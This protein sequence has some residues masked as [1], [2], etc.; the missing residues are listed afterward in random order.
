M[1]FVLLPLTRNRTFLYCY[2]RIPRPPKG[3]NTKSLSSSN[4][5]L[6]A[7]TSDE[8]EPLPSLSDT[9]N[10]V[11]DRMTSYASTKW[12][13]WEHEPQGSMKRTITAY[14]NKALQRIP[15]EEWGLKS[16][17][18]LSTKRQNTLLSLKSK[19]KDAAAAAAEQMKKRKGKLEVV[20]PGAAVDMGFPGSIGIG[21][22]KL[23]WPNEGWG[24]L[25][26]T[27]VTEVLRELATKRQNLHRKRMWGCLIGLPFT[28]PVG[29]LPIIPNI[30]GFYLTFRAWSHYR[31]LRGSQHLEFLLNENLTY[32]SPS[33][34]LATIY[35]LSSIR[36]STSDIR[37]EIEALTAQKAKPL[38]DVEKEN[39]ETPPPSAHQNTVASAPGK[40]YSPQQQGTD[41]PPPKEEAEK[42]EETGTRQS[43]KPT[44][45]PSA[46]SSPSEL[47][48][49]PLLI[50]SSSAPLIADA[51]GMPE[52][53]DELER[54]IWQIERANKAAARKEK[55]N[56]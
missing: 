46:L 37:K 4:I 30:P 51:L 17:P 36:A 49:D 45:S 27:E 10:N 56:A 13:E 8:T 6:P 28:L 25:K 29:I 55:A 53:E 19:H 16:I 32:L 22:G 18:P 2:H 48:V 42:E 34:T 7:K 26:N 43:S 47:A 3:S 33:S 38:K 31:A 23:E 15:Y 35:A 40:K 44:E 1:R 41:R 5:N 54:A 21:Q 50:D 20:F 11:S 39:G 9:F 52:L 12:I 14:G 24:Q